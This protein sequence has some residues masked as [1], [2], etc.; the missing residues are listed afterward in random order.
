MEN[1]NYPEEKLEV[2][3]RYLQQE[4]SPDEKYQLEEELSSSESLREQ[5]ALL[6]HSQQA[7]RALAVRERVQAAR[8]RASKQPKGKQVFFGLNSR[9]LTAVAAVLLPL[10]VVGILFSTNGSDSVYSENYL[11]YQLPVNRSTEASTS[12]IETLFQEKEY[13]KVVQEF[14]KRNDSNK[15]QQDIFLAALASMELS[16]FEQAVQLLESLKK[17]NSEVDDKRFEQESDFY[18]ALAYVKTGQVFKA[19]QLFEKIRGNKRHLYHKNIS[20]WDVWRLTFF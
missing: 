14:S 4:L 17:R 15:D 11:S 16:D 12:T 9:Q 5:L 13:K 7:I 20:Y 10:I 8:D 19:Q 3:E 2:L 1:K 18:L 6:Q